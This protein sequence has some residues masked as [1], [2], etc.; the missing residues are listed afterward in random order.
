MTLPPEFLKNRTIA[1]MFPGEEGFAVPWAMG[2][3]E[4]RTCFLNGSH[5]ITDDESAVST[6]KVMR[7]KDGSYAVDISRCVGERWPTSK[8]GGIG[9]VEILGGPERKREPEKEETTRDV[10]KRKMNL[11]Q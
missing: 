3:R 1:G 2:V 9:V 11:G 7:R 8:A 10:K 4:D 5:S 6:M